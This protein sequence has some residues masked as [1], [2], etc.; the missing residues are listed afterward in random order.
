MIDNTAHRALFSLPPIQ[1]SARTD[2]DAPELP[3]QQT[4][5][6]DKEVDAVLWLRA[7]ISTGQAPLIEKAREAARRIKTPLKELEKRYTAHLA[8]AN[9]GNPFATMSSIG[10]ADLSKLEEKSIQLAARR[11][12]AKTRFGDSLFS[13]TPAECFCAESLSSV[14]K[15]KNGWSLDPDQV[16]VRFNERADYRPATLS[17]CIHE[18]T[19]WDQLYWLRNAVDRDIEDSEQADARKEFVFRCLARIRPRNANEAAS[20]L[21]YLIDHDRMGRTET[22]SILLNLIGAP[23]PYGQEERNAN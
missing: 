21:R 7:V 12:E 16:D 6:G 4:V 1:L 22:N 14:A 19:F 20:V 23:E 8:R 5:T 15:G 2:L 13:D 17:D 9:P 11:Q 10:F 18:L 3:P